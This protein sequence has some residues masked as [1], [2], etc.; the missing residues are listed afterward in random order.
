MIAMLE[1]TSKDI[2][3]TVIFGARFEKDIYYKEV[4]EKF[5]NT[6]VIISVSKPSENYK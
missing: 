4:L 3:K 1:N 2:K 5:E 6:K